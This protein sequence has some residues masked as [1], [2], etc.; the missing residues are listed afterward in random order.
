MQ[1]EVLKR[2]RT[3]VYEKKRDQRELIKV[4]QRNFRKYMSMREW[5]WFVIIQRTR[6][7][8]G[9]PNPE[10][11]LRVLEEQANAVYGKYDEQVKT[12]A[13][14]LE[15]NETIKEE[16]KALLAQLEKEQGNL[17]VYHEK[18]AAA[19]AGIADLEKQLQ[20][21]QD[22]LAQREQARQDA[23]QDKKVLEQEVVA[24]KK[25][26]D[27]IMVA[28]QKLEQEK[29]NRDHTIK[30]LNDEIANQDEVINKLN[31]EKK[32]ISENAAKSQ[33]D[34][35]VAED[36]VGHL[37]QIKNKLESTLDELES[38]YEKEK[39][40]RANIEKER[41]KIEGE[42]KISRSLRISSLI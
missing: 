23:T 38:S 8:I 28:I 9:R 37:N 36:K 5:G 15:E 2:I 35:Q 18:Q 1:G 32:H 42:L 29:T 41:R 26:I 22:K 3:E 20:V 21:A 17:S 39:R 12:K 6:P 7:M 14:L 16:K 31:K 34:L 10:E 33:E 40:G 24:I 25:D 19:T 4:C 11:E 27:D 30:S 13:R